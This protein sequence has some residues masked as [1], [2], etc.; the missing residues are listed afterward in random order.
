MRSDRDGKLRRIG[1]AMLFLTN[2][3]NT[4]VLTVGLL[5]AEVTLDS[6]AV[7]FQSVNVPPAL[8]AQGYSAEVA[9]QRIISGALAVVR[10]ARTY[11][12]AQS[13]QSANSDDSVEL[14]ASYLGMR[15]L[16]Q[17]AQQAAGGLEYKVA[18][19]IVAEPE[20]FVLRM[21][22]SR[23]D[24]R[25]VRARVA[26]P[27]DQAEALLADGGFMLLRLIDPHVACSAILRRSASA[28]VPDVQQTIQCVEESLAASGDEDRTWLYNLLGVARV[29][30]GETEGAL[31]AF[32]SALRVDPEFSPSLLNLGILFAGADRHA[33][34]L[35]AY[36]AVF[37]HRGVGDSPQTYAA[38]YA[39]R[40]M[41][42]ER[43][44]RHREALDS[45]RRAIREDPGYYLP[46]Q[47]LLARLPAATA[48]AR[49]L[50]RAITEVHLRNATNPQDQ[51]YTDNLL[52]MLPI[53]SLLR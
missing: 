23:F 46:Q 10:D 31:S 14:I 21:R 25:V 48:E 12:E 27:K 7:S 32:Q 41:S 37:R 9:Q 17:A 28:G 38:T 20:S 8:V 36:A 29:L 44:G 50:R 18:A 26:R 2:L 40:A 34:A 52:G 49:A 51:I 24:G 11:R 45:L 53:T 4:V 39:M 47:L 6:R 3:F 30:G 33:D 42:L 5:A 13:V 1:S 16:L 43:L 19:D 15:P 22:V 35:R